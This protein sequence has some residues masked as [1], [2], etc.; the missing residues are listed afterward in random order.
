MQNRARQFSD[1]SVAESCIDTSN[2]P[3]KMQCLLK[4]Q[5]AHEHLSHECVF[6]IITHTQSVYNSIDLK[7]I[8]DVTNHL[9]NYCTLH[10]HMKDQSTL[11]TVIVEILSH[12]IDKLY[13]GTEYTI[14]YR[15][16]MKDIIPSY[17]TILCNKRNQKRFNI[18]GR[19]AK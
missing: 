9:Y 2:H 4:R 7:N 13:I 16:V 14:V 12:M 11:K 1:M 19:W 3:Q 8:L 15:P 10:L 17:I 5:P 6:N 18:F